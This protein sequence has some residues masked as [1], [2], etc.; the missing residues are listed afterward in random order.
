[1]GFHA[2]GRGFGGFGA[3]DDRRVPKERRG[4]TI[5]RIAAFFKPYRLAIS[6]VL[7]TIVITSLLGIINPDTG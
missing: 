5:R 7:I 1:M 6:A 2:G 3:T 4:H